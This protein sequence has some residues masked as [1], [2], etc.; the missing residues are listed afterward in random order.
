LLT[1]LALPPA[2]PI[3]SD[4]NSALSDP[5]AVAALELH[6]YP[7]RRPRRYWR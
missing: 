7:P 5:V 4:N 3:V 2:P 1:V 6:V